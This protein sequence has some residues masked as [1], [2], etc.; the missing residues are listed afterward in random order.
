MQ[1]ALDHAACSSALIG[2]PRAGHLGRDPQNVAKLEIA[3]IDPVLTGPTSSHQYRAARH[4][5]TQ[6]SDHKLP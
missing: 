5:K 3:G 1:S 2:V 6:S 4:D